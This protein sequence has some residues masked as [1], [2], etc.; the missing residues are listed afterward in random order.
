MPEQCEDENSFLLHEYDSWQNKGAFGPEIPYAMPGK[1]T[2]CEKL[3]FEPE[4]SLEPTGR[5]ANTPTGLNVNIHIPQNENPNGLATPPVKSTI[6]T[7]PQGMTV[8]PGFADGL[9]GCSEAQ[10]GISSSRGPQ[11]RPGLLS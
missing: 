2:G 8:N 5:Q 1:M 11:R 4:V 7:L 6:V 9:A 10:I 3:R